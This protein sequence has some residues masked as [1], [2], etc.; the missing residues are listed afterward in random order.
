MPSGTVITEIRE[1]ARLLRRLFFLIV[2]RPLVTVVLGVNL[3]HSERL[4]RGGPAILVANHNSHLDTLVLMTLLPQQLL[5]RIRPVAA[6][7]YFLKA[8]WLAWFATRIVGIIPLDRRPKP[9][10]DPLAGATAALDRGDILILFPEGT[11]GEPE[12]LQAFKTGVAHLAKRRPEVPVVP[13][14]LH[15]LGKALP[16]DAFLLVPFFIDIFVGDPVLWSGE[17]GDFMARLERTMH[18][19]AAECRAPAWD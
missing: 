16:K 11:R 18:E 7:D 3:R 5:P 13:V 1:P 9:G 8:R 19:L 6:I 4:P 17:R 14:F 15:G 10:I 2:V 12:R